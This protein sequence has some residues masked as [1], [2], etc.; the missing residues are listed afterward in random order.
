M[1][2][3][4][5]LVIVGAS[6]AGA[7]AAEG[8]RTAGFDGRV[9]LIGD[10]HARPYERPPLSKAVLRGEADPETTRVH[11]DDFY[12]THS[13]ELLTGRT[14]EALD[15]DAH[16]VRLDGNDVLTF[17]AAVLTTGATP[18]QLDIPGSHLS[19]VH[20]L[21]RIDDSRRL[22]DAIRDAGRVAVIGAG[23]IGSEVAA[24][25]RQMAADVVLVDPA[26]TPLH[27]VLGDEIGD[28][29]RRLHADRGVA[30]RLGTGLA[31]LRGADR[32][33]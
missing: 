21:R 15:P 3:D 22:G 17:S 33:E 7:K 19:G 8:A 12:A 9:V 6:L 25:A 11:D 2:T 30:L 14:V 27:A 29:F 32:V 23:W 16:Q 5:T 18:R 13:I 4:Q 31:E 28:V 20:Y 1:T 24:S 26:P 10:E